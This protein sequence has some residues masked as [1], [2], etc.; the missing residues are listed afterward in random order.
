VLR[1]LEGVEVLNGS[2]FS[3]RRVGTGQTVVAQLPT[4]LLAGGDYELTL[5]GMTPGGG[6]EDVDEYYFRIVKK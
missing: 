6:Y 4:R 5:Q 2:G 3:A 1:T